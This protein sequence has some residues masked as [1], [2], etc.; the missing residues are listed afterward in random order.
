M[1]YLASAYTHPD[2]DVREFR[3]T[4]AVEYVTYAVPYFSMLVFSPIAYWHPI[5]LRHSLPTDSK[6]WAEVNRTTFKS[7]AG[8]L[9]LQSD[10]WERS[11]GIGMEVKW[12]KDKGIPIH[13]TGLKA[14]GGIWTQP[15]SM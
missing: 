3:Y 11:V 5:A 9:I 7:V 1:L 10:G 4:M 13:M 15:Y 6:Y 8:L 2:A 14:A 12:A